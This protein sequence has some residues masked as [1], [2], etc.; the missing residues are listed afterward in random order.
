[1]AAKERKDSK[2]TVRLDWRFVE[3]MDRSITGG[4]NETSQVAI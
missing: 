2:K 4:A 3:S 1:M